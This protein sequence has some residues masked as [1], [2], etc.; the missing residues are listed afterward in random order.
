[1]KPTS[2]IFIIVSVILACVG[3]LLC[4]SANNMANEQGIGLFSQTGDADNNFFTTHEFDSSDLKKIV[5]TAG[6]VDVNVYGGAA[7]DMIELVNF[8]AG[9]YD[10]TVSK[11]TLQLS[12]NQGIASLV[13]LDNF[14]INFNGFRDYL[15]YFKYRDKA[16]TVNLYVTDAATVVNLI[17]TSESG[18]IT[19]NNLHL[20]KDTEGKCYCDYKIKVG[21]GN[22]TISHVN[23]EST[24]IIESSVD[25]K[26]N[27]TGLQ[28]NELQ[29]NAVKGDLALRQ[30]DFR[31]RLFV[32]IKSGNV[33][34]DRTEDNFSE[35][36]VL[37]QA[38][39]GLLRVYGNTV[40]S[41]KYTEDNIVTPIVGPE[42]TTHAAEGGEETTAA[43]SGE[44]T[45]DSV[46]EPDTIT[47]IVEDGNVAVY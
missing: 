22:V 7:K 15:N 41:G 10:Y 31:H 42:D 38:G 24:M 25:S 37:L 45:D 44:K 47:I 33:D 23:T 12:D 5:I 27:V 30:I 21:S 46:P 13:D 32:N 14:K 16:R 19:L 34:Y 6:D 3:V 11:S 26:I 2:I 35:L 36:N 39:N 8:N 29:V 1:M 9:T 4:I 18:N 43:E 20:N 40:T 17:I 28:C